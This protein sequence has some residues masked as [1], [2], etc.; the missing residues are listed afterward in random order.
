MINYN[1]KTFVAKLNS[2]N[3][4][5]DQLTVFKY[6]Q[7]DKMIWG[8][9]AGG[10]IKKGFLIGTANEDSSLEFFYQHLNSS[11]LLKAGKC[12][13]TPIILRDGR[14]ELHETWQW[15]C[16]DFSKG[17]SILIEKKGCEHV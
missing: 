11:N 15:L 1:N 14:I 2:E 8:N 10:Q 4:E 12:V 6:Y 9:Y 16:D 7:N 17:K 3:G 13:S 5:V